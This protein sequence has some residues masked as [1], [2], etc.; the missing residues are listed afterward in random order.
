MTGLR[1]KVLKSKGQPVGLGIRI[2]RWFSRI[3]AWFQPHDEGR[4]PARLAPALQ[5][6]VLESRPPAGQTPTGRGGSQAVGGPS[7][8]PRRAGG[9]VF[10]E[11]ERKCK[12]CGEPLLNGGGLVGCSANPAHRIHALCV[13]LAGHKCPDCQ[14]ALG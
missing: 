6:R 13:G 10:N 1:I 8:R 12:T 11:G 4:A 14:A 5:I 2:K 9:I 7:R 3:A